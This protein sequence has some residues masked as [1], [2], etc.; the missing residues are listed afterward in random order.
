MGEGSRDLPLDASTGGLLGNACGYDD[1]GLAAIGTLQAAASTVLW[2]GGLACGSRYQVACDR[3][4]AD[5]RWCKKGAT[6]T[7]TVTDFCPPNPLLPS[8]NGGWCNPP[9]PHF[10]LSEQAFSKIGVT[11]GSIIPVL[12]K[13][14]E[15]NRTT[16]LRFKITGLPLLNDVLVD[17]NSAAGTTSVQVKGTNTGWLDMTHGQGVHWESIQLLQGQALSFKVTNSAGATVTRENVFPANWQYGQTA[18]AA[19]F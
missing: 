14:S 16:P 10:D 18:T 17:S 13:Q 9:R 6:V 3:K 11:Q 8:D 19:G 2:N 5:P 15:V 1:A 7:V 4:L 12:Y